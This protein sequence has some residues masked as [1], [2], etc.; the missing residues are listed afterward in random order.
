MKTLAQTLIFTAV[1]VLA[2]GAADRAV[3]Y[4]GYGGGY[5]GWYGAAGLGAYY[6]NPYSPSDRRVPYFAEH[7]PVYYSYPVARTYGY[8]PYASP[9]TYTVPEVRAEPVIIENPHV[10]A[11]PTSTKVEDRAAD[12]R[13]PVEPLVI[14]NPYVT[15]GPA[16]AAG[17]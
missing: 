7:P 17:E 6:A 14:Y 3:A 16:I 5:G 11:K 8:S 2:V 9:P 13:R 12:H 1:V 15:G 10:K 4:G